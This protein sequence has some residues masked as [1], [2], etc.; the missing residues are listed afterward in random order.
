VQTTCGIKFFKS[1]YLRQTVQLFL[2]TVFIIPKHFLTFP[3]LPE[4]KKCPHRNFGQD[5]NLDADINFGT[6][7]VSCPSCPPDIATISS[8]SETL[9][10]LPNI[11][12]KAPAHRQ[13]PEPL[14]HLPE[15]SESISDII[16]RPCKNNQELCRNPSD[17]T[18]NLQKVCSRSRE[19]PA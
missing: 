18:E 5:Q 3:H 10:C 14:G 9:L 11:V 7:S 16:T 13:C 19:S 8:S 6:P 15:R 17:V 4:V 12:L 1:S 2:D